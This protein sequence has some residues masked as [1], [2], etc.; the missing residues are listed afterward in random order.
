MKNLILTVAIVLFGITAFAQQITK[1]MQKP[2]FMSPLSVQLLTGSQGVGADIKYG[3]LPR[4]SGRLGFGLIPVD[5]GRA[6]KFASFPVF[7]ELNT[8]FS[9][10]HLLADYAPFKN[11][12][13]LRLVG[14]AAYIVNGSAQ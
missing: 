4:L 7:G 12:S 8:R 9:N 11:K 13:F 1:A 5:A 2:V 3:F 6:F 10:V 14:G